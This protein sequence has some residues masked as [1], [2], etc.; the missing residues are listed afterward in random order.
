M[1]TYPCT[2]PSHI[3]MYPSYIRMYDPCLPSLLFPIPS[4][5]PPTS[6]IHISEPRPAPNHSVPS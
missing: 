1:Y 4:P 5:I 3:C 2:Q 6:S